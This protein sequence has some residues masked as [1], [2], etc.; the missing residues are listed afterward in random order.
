M[1]IGTPVCVTGASGFIASQIVAQLLAKG[2]VVHATVRD[3]QNADKT[4]FLTSL[5]GAAERL[6][7]FSA[8]LQEQ[9]GFEAAIAGCKAVFHIASPLP[10]GKVE[11]PEAMIIKP[12]VEGVLNV[13][14]ASKKL[15]VKS[16]VMTSSMAAVAP[17]PE[18][19]LKN[20][21]H[22]SDPEKQKANSSFYG[23]SKT[24]AEQ[25]AWKFVEEEGAPFRL[26]TICPTMVVG[27][28]LQPSANATM[29]S[30]CTMLKEGCKG[31]RCANDSMSFIDVRDC[32][33]QHIAAMADETA[34]GRYM[35]VVASV[36]WNDLEVLMRE[37]YPMMPKS[38]PCEGEPVKP[39]QFDR[40]R[41]ES[42]KVECRDVPQI[43]REAMEELKLKGLLE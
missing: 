21:E 30:L 35:S 20:E 5:P 17:K 29:M 2:Y 31:G 4:A 23:A 8:D 39:T 1:E 24:L 28:M 15:G 16:V 38:E 12:A 40:T 6:K 42:L 43:I 13:F 14:R 9:A 11:D 3:A 7:F 10:G 34:S 33:A 37:I 32:A 18:P 27:P 25:A 36:H 26:A 22:W 19:P 41:Q